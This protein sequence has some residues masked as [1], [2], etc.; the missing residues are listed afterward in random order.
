[1][2]RELSGLGTEGYVVRS[3]KTGSQLTIVIASQSDI[4][5]LYGTFHFLRLMQTLQSIENINISEK[6][7]LRL[8]VLDH[9]DNL[10]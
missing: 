7:H 5:A 2:Q 4:G 6:P 9:W 10:D 8:R 1:M 3:I